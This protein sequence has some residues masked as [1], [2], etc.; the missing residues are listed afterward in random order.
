MNQRINESIS[1]HLS[2]GRLRHVRRDA[3]RRAA[4]A[5]DPRRSGES[6]RRSSSRS[7][8]TAPASRCAGSSRAP[9]SSRRCSGAGRRRSTAGARPSPERSCPRRASASAAPS[10]SVRSSA[11]GHE[12]GVHAWDHVGWH[13]GLDRMS[14]EGGSRGDRA[15][16]RRVPRDLRARRRALRPRRAGRSRRRRSRSRRSAVSSTRRTRAAA[17]RSFPRAAGRVFSHARDSFDAARRWTRRSPGRSYSGRRGRSGAS[18]ARPRAGV[19]VH[20][21]H[22]EVEGRSKAPLFAKI[23]DDWLGGRGRLSAPLGSRAGEASPAASA[24]PSARVARTTLPGRGG[25]VATGWPSEDRP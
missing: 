21:I 8:P 24:F 4:P 14:R 25:T 16:A 23:L 9:G 6:A 5:R 7:G 13:D 3:R 2:Q 20:T 11:A 22:A 1:P 17:P 19:E 10:R 12:T 15:R 18:F